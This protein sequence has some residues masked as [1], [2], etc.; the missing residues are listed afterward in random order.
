MKYRLRPIDGALIAMLI[1]ISLARAVSLR[2]H[3]WASTIVA[4]AFFAMIILLAWQVW[5]WVTSQASRSSETPQG[6]RP[7]RLMLGLVVLFPCGLLLMTE[8]IDAVARR[9]SLFERARVSVADSP[10][11]CQEIGCPI[12]IGWPIEA[13]ISATSDSGTGS[14]EVPL[15]GAKG[16][17][18]LFAEGTKENGVW[19]LS[20]EYFTVDGG[21]ALQIAR[22]GGR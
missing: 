4:I 13:S 17:A 21:R 2:Q 20:R 9:T 3:P 8:V 14:I 11:L 5:G 15:L 22:P 19:T 18:K 16:H 7:V 10:V 12:S 6:R 1:V